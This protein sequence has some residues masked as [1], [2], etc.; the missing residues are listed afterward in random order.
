MLELIGMNK[1]SPS[2]ALSTRHTHSD[3]TR[4]CSGR[5]GSIVGMTE[6]KALALT[7]DE[8]TSIT[9]GAKAD[10]AGWCL[11]ITLIWCL[12]GCILFFYRRLT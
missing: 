11:Y 3:M 6:A 2:P 10:I 12:K 8:R 4:N 7:D 5:W 1:S 9:N